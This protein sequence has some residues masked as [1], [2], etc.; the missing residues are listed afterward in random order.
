MATVQG[1]RADGKLALEWE[2]LLAQ[3]AKHWE[4]FFEAL[5]ERAPDDERL[6]QLSEAAAE[7]DEPPPAGEAQAA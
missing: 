4:E 7:A 6:R 1:M 5:A 2:H 3:A